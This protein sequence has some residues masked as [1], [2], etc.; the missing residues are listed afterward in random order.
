MSRFLV[1]GRSGQ[2]ARELATLLPDADFMGREQIDLAQTDRIA[3]VIEELRPAAI[4]NAAAYTAVDKAET[5][6]DQ[7]RLLN[8]DAPAQM[9]RTAARLDIPFLHISTDYVFDGSGDQPWQEGDATGPL[10]IYG[11]TKLAGER[12]IAAQDG[13]WA[14]MRTSWV[15][16]RHGNNFV[17]KML[18]LGRERDALNIVADQ[19][20][21]PTAAADIAR[22]L[23]AMANN[24]V[25]GG[26]VRGLYHYSGA[27]AVSW[28]DFAREIFAQAQIDCEVRDIATADY[29]T[30]ARRPGNS[31][32]DC[33]R[34]QKDLGVRQPDWREGLRNVLVEWDKII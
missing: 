20:G 8:S 2:V 10:G 17:K 19:V 27:P 26:E 28:A 13:R 11:K 29:P 24:M 30:P 3:A 9:A 15:F 7:A 18:R 5:E 4:I 22:T 16:S 6:Q 1:F 21:G 33:S 12:E 14:V 32:L 25:A 34:L 31:R 23:V